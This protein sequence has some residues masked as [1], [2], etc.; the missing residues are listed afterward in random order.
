MRDVYHINSS[1]VKATLHK[2]HQEIDNFSAEIIDVI[3]YAEQ[4][5]E[6]CGFITVTVNRTRKL[7]L[8]SNEMEYIEEKI[9]NSNKI[10]SWSC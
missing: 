9:Y 6:G 1:N 7:A 10:K 2:L 3:D 4:F 5:A 8:F